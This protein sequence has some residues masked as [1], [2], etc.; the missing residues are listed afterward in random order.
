[1]PK[2]E[3]VRWQHRT[4]QSPP[5]RQAGPPGE[6]HTF[7]TDLIRRGTDWYVLQLLLGY[8]SAQRPCPHT[9]T[10]PSIT[11]AAPSSPRD[12]SMGDGTY[13][14]SRSRNSI[15]LL[16]AYIGLPMAGTHRTPRPRPPPA[17]FHPTPRPPS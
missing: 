12:G 4:A 6:R 2:G 5:D 14:A 7:A 1:M 8:C 15:P 17:T 10:S 3:Q 9:A 13:P 16:V 11:R